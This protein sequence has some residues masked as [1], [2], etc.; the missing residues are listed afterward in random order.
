MPAWVLLELV[1]FGSFIDFYL[2]GA[3]R[4]GDSGMKEER[5]MLR[6]VKAARA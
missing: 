6:S 4:W 2:F 5:Y 1:S 3:Q